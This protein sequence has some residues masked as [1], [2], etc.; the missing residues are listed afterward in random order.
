MNA[1]SGNEIL[2]TGQTFANLCVQSCKKLLAGIDEAKNRIENEFQE[3]FKS[4]GQLLHLALNEADALSR[5]T[6]YPH[7]LFPTLAVEKVQ[8][9]AAWKTRQQSLRRQHLIVAEVV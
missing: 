6:A 3:A 5:Q 4:H 1:K 7:L 2:T 8:V 9:V